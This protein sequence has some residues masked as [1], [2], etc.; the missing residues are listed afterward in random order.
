MLAVA[1]ARLPAY[2]SLLFTVTARR[3]PRGT[4]ATYD[5]KAHGPVNRKITIFD[6]ISQQKVLG[7]V[8]SQY[9]L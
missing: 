4:F 7:L 3:K 5:K 1:R 2:V 6:F 9:E 8:M